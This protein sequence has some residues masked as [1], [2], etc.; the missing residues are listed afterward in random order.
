MKFWRLLKNNS[1]EK[2]AEFFFLDLDDDV[3]GGV[4]PD[5]SEHRKSNEEL[6]LDGGG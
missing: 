3:T 6:H 4:S 5:N 2:G 1:P